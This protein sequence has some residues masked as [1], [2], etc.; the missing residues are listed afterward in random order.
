MSVLTVLCHGTGRA[1]VSAQ[2]EKSDELISWLG[3]RLEGPRA[4]VEYSSG[5]ITRRAGS[6]II[7][8]GPGHGEEGSP[9]PQHFSAEGKINQNPVSPGI[10]KFVGNMRG[11]GWTTNVER[12][13]GII[14]A[15][16]KPQGVTQVNFCGWS[17]G[18]VTCIR[19]MS[20]A[21]RLRIQPYIRA[22][23]SRA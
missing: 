8:D 4:D 6:H 10:S 1:Q 11:T 14:K 23:I 17:R 21:S 18:A 7:N 2:H 13:M 12:T 3:N 20:S 15:I 16:G 5:T 22:S 9:L 19:I